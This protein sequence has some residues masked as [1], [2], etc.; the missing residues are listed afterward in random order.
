MKQK[1]LKHTC[2]LVVLSVILTFLAA[3]IVMYQ[4]YNEDLKQSVRDDTIY[5]KDGIEKMGEEYLNDNPGKE[6]AVRNHCDIQKPCP[7]RIFTVPDFWMM[8]I[9]FVWEEPQTVYFLR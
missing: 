2:V 9:F 5:I 8:A 6:T 3:S 1:I 4:K 7:N